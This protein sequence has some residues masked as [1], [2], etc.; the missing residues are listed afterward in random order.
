MT[1]SRPHAHA[2][3]RQRTETESART[4][5]HPAIT[6]TVRTHKRRDAPCCDTGDAGTLPLT[7]RRETRGGKGGNTVAVAVNVVFVILALLALYFVF[8]VPFYNF[9]ARRDRS[10]RDGFI[11]IFLLLFTGAILQIL[12]SIHGDI[13]RLVR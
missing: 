12:W 10:A 9:L 1:G 13:A 3:W 5:H 6:Q 11:L 7:G 4:I 2:E 8:V